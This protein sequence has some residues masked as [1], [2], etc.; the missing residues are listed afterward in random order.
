MKTQLLNLKPK[1]LLLAS[2]MV[3]TILAVSSQAYAIVGYVNLPLTNGYN[4]VA[5]QLD[6]DGTGTHNTLNS[7]MGANYVSGTKVYVWDVTNQVF[8]PPSTSPVG[9]NDW[10]PNYNVP[11]GKG[12][13]IWSNTNST[14]VTFVGQV[15]QGTL[16][17]PVAGANKFSLLG[18]MIPIGGP[19]TT[20]YAIP[21][22]SSSS[23]A[24]PAIDGANTFTFDAVNQRYSDAF[25]F[26]NPLGWADAA[27][28]VGLNGPVV[29]V[30]QAFFVQNPGPDTNWIQVFTVSPRGLTSSQQS[31]AGAAP[32]ASPDIRQ[33]SLNSGKV[34]LQITNPGGTAFS[35]QFSPDGSAWT[36][37]AA[38]QT[39][40]AWSGPLPGSQRGYFRLTSP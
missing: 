23:L 28:I 20:N 36:T 14:L 31:F 9:T 33:M 34:T 26:L 11:T 19:L 22:S 7:M 4:F 39:G 27:G 24:F 1:S 3:A 21:P 32:M 13:V 15:L 35:V 17:N 10:N 2:G 18:S 29:G 30:G 25:T 6:F 16:I 38:S 12:F 37:L 8:L 5:D 40:S